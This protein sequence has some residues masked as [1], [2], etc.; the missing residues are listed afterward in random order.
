MADKLLKSDYDNHYIEIENKINIIMRQTNYTYEESKIKLELF[1]NDH[2]QVIKDY[3]G[4]PNNRSNKITSI[5]QEIY[6][7]IRHKL[8]E[9]QNEY[10]SK[11]PLDINKVITD[12]N[13]KMN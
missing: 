9:S 11:N 13:G 6:K 2:I 10:N 8:N 3:M 5:N 1:N 7:Q 12:L 4:I